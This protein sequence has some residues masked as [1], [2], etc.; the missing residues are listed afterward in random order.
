MY[1]M[2]PLL[3]L[4]CTRGGVIINVKPEGDNPAHKVRVQ[5]VADGI[6]RISATDAASFPK[7]KSL[8]IKEQPRFSEY[9]VSENGDTVFVST[10]NVTASVL[11]STGEVSFFSS[12]GKLLLKEM[13]GGGK[14]FLPSAAPDARFGFTCTF[15]SPDDE[16][17]YGLGQHQSGEYNYKGR[18]EILFQY[19]SKVSIPYIYSNKGYG[20]YFDNY[21]L[22]KWGNPADY[23]QLTDV[24]AVS[25]TDGVPGALT[26]TYT[27]QNGSVYVRREPIVDFSF[28]SREDKL[29]HVE[30]V[31]DEVRLKG[32][33]VVFE[34]DVKA[35]ESG[36]YDFSL[37]YGGYVR[38]LLDSEEVVPERWRAAWNPNTWKFSVDF[39]KGETKHLRIEWRPD[40]KDSYCSLK[41]KLPI[42][43]AE[44]G[45]QRWTFEAADCIDWYFI[46]G[47]T[48]DQVVKGYRTLT[49]KAQMMPKWALGYWQS[50]E[51]YKTQDQILQ[52]AAEFRKRR[53][54]LDNIVLDWN[55]WKDDGWGTHEFDSLR[56]P[57]PKAMVDSLHGMNVNI[58]ISVWPK[59]Y[60]GT[61]HF[62]EFD[63]KGWMYPQAV[64]DSIRDWIGPGYMYSFYDAYDDGAKKLF[65]KQISDHL[66]PL[67]FDAWWLDASE[68]G[69]C[70][71]T[72]IQ[73]RKD[74][75]G[76]TSCGSSTK[77]FNAYPLENAK[78]VYNGQ[79]RDGDSRVFIL[80]RSAFAGIQNY[81]TAVWSGD[82][83]AR[84]EE[85][86]AQIAA[87]LNFSICGI[88]YWTQDLGGFTVE[89]RYIAAQNLFNRTGEVTPDEEEW[90]ELN[91]RWYQFGVFCPL[92]RGHGQYPFREIW[93]IAPQGH[94]CYE[95]FEKYTRMRYAL[96][97]Y[98]YSLAGLV[99]YEDYTI[100]R[101]L[102]MD[103]Q[104][105]AA[106]G[107]I[108]D[109]FMFGPSFMVAPVCE[110]GQRERRMY[111]PAGRLWYQ[112]EGSTVLEG[113][114]W[115]VVDAPYDRIPVYV[116]SGAIIP[117]VEPM[118]Y[119]DEFLP[120]S[121]TIDVYAGND[122]QFTL[123]EDNGL[124]YAYEEGESRLIPFKWNDA[125][126][127][128][129]VG[130][131][132]GQYT[133][134]P[135]WRTFRCRLHTPEGVIAAE[136]VRYE[137][138]SII[139]KFD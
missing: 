92:Y 57:D 37:Y 132:E 7:T 42:S 120:E 46:S 124:D 69:V 29:S 96:M 104:Y 62:N 131:S 138:K 98:I 97:P 26:G 87:G 24:F 101:P 58:M 9:K 16:A 11:K 15:E 74:L 127:T 39:N 71:C 76:P 52:T 121:M 47:E 136:D 25:D 82:I 91:A 34:G 126:R 61:E 67:G 56:F 85:M 99:H 36:R 20:L 122:G 48:A 113:G 90:R 2:I 50:R 110:Y 19:N 55:Y 123:Y 107:D 116:P 10:S 139:V 103:F 66:V 80:T 79:R 118:Q 45:L 59:F 40:S 12:D 119:V 95:S 22:A 109:Q 14:T 23:L 27:Q 93:N 105:D 1:A 38:V 86:R 6:F 53:L 60:V 43:E 49:G 5:P 135:E 73:Y 68:A 17:F 44:R 117:K 128:L 134:A 84:W 4:S 77:Y 3:V 33:S 130:T 78:A 35:L 41:A 32:A 115:A 75:C 89:S 65:W 94:P 133:G 112:L 18:D 28:L 100:M 129:T 83:A 108:S 51:R 30:N 31:P 106:V 64:R 102:F 13:S 137:G 81:S 63:S 114:K 54:P 125:G 72:D 70:K 88:P 8:V 111:F 21:S